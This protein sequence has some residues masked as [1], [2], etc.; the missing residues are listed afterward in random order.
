MAKT[1]GVFVSYVREEDEL[2]Q[3]SKKVKSSLEDA[4]VVVWRDESTSHFLAERTQA[5]SSC[6]SLVCVITKSYITSVWC[7]DELYKA[8][9]AMEDEGDKLIVPLVFENVDWDVDFKDV[10]V[11]ARFQ[12]ENVR[13]LFGSPLWTFCRP[14][15]D[16]Y[17]T[18]MQRLISQVKKKGEPQVDW[19][20]SDLCTCGH[21][22]SRRTPPLDAEQRV[23][24][25][26]GYVSMRTRYTD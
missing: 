26:T 7:Q 1:P 9:M 14:R 18:A 25:Q 15:R 16:D 6:H 2:V 13:F 17:S 22:Q 20:M 23:E 11:E 10:G 4:G 24:S 21:A 3:F 5:L 19:L 8:Y 12:A